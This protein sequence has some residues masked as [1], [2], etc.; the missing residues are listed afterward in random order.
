MVP[1]PQPVHFTLYPAAYYDLRCEDC[2]LHDNCPND[3]L[4]CGYLSP[5]CGDAT[6]WLEGVA[7]SYAS[8]A[9]SVNAFLRSCN[10]GVLNG[11]VFRCDSIKSL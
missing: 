7:P 2:S 3:G 1:Q 6:P 10:S 8:A 4:G 9:A 5:S 11:Y